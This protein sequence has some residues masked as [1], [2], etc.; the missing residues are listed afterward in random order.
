MHPSSF[1]DI[2]PASP[3][4]PAGRVTV[5][6]NRSVSMDEAGDTLELAKLATACLHG[7]ERVELET[8]WSL[9]RG[10]RRV[11]VDT[12]TSAGRTLAM[13]FLGYVRREFGTRAVRAQRFDA[14]RHAARDEQIAGAA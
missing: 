12:D 4:P 7:D 1:P 10:G 2:S 5:T 8:R 6:F 11:T 14:P 3:A 13:I 9:D